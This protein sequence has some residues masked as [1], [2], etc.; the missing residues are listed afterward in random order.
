MYVHRDAMTDKQFFTSAPYFLALVCETYNTA[1][2]DTM[3]DEKRKPGATVYVVRNF[4]NKEGKQDSSWLKVG[5]AWM[6][7]DQEGF[8]V[9]LE[10]VPVTGRLVIRA[11]KPKE[12]Q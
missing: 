7:K 8:D 12:K 5:V 6:H 3:S 2:G 11:N 10:A 9:L 4:E 1:M